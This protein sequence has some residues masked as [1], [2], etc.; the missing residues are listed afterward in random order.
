MSRSNIFFVFV[1]FLLGNNSLVKIKDT[2]SLW[3]NIVSNTCLGPL[4]CANSHLLPLP[5]RSYF[6]SY[7]NVLHNV[8]HLSNMNIIA[9]RTGPV[10]VC[11]YFCP[12]EQMFTSFQ[13]RCFVKSNYLTLE[14]GWGPIRVWTFWLVLRLVCMCVYEHTSVPKQGI[15]HLCYPQL[16]LFGKRAV[17]CVHHL[18]SSSDSVV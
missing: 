5:P 18:T 17:T 3:L 12:W 10:F 7:I 15:R 6:S 16:T 9:E 14:L 4:L 8:P 1:L 13:G 11:S 2:S